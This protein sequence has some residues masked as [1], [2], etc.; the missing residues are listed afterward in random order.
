ML[1]WTSLAVFLVAALV[2]GISHG[3]VGIAYSRLAGGVVVTML[4]WVLAFRHT[5]ITLPDV[6]RHVWRPVFATVM[7]GAVL[8]SLPPISKVLPIDLAVT[9]LVGAAVYVMSLGL[10]WL[11]AS[12]PDGIERVV[13]LRLQAM[14]AK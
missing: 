10:A 2:F 14:L 3:L 7:M 8:Q 5:S 13:V 9:V 1:T 12:K 4:A 11:G 6:V